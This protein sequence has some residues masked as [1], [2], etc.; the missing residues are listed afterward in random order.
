MGGNMGENIP[1][2]GPRKGAHYARNLHEKHIGENKQ[3][4][5]S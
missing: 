5:V 3:V 1:Y 2:E 4:V